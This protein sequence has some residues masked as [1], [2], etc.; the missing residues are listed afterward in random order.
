MEIINQ[1][2]LG[3]EHERHCLHGQGFALTSNIVLI[4]YPAALEYN[5]ECKIIQTTTTWEVGKGYANLRV[6]L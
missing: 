3:P 6:R 4:A 5:T 2:Q 1:W